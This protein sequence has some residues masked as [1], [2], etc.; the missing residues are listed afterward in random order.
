MVFASFGHAEGTAHAFVKVMVHFDPPNRMLLR[1]AFAITVFAHYRL[2]RGV[3]PYEDH[4]EEQNHPDRD[5]QDVEGTTEQVTNHHGVML[6]YSTVLAVGAA[7]LGSGD[8]APSLDGF[9]QVEEPRCFR[10]LKR[11]RG[12]SLTGSL[13]SLTLITGGPG[14]ALLTEPRRCQMGCAVADRQ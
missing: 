4:Y 7:R 6:A 8:G 11:S 3:H 14:S 1:S 9:R 10:S 2:P 5:D 12:R 13:A